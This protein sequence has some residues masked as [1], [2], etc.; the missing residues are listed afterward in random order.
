MPPAW[1]PSALQKAGVGSRRGSV[2]LSLTSASFGGYTAAM[3][4]ENAYIPGIAPTPFA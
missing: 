2:Q 1:R 4:T 3:T